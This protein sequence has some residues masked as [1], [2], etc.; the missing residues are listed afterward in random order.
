MYPFTTYMLLFQNWNHVV[1]NVGITVTLS[2][3]NYIKL[4]KYYLEIW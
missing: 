2:Y 4:F 1:L 3:G